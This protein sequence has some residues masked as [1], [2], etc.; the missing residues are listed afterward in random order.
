MPILALDDPRVARGVFTVREAAGYLAMP[1]STLSDWAS[2]TRSAPTIST[3]AGPRGS[4][5]VPFIGFAEAFVLAAFRRAGLPLQRIRPAVAILRDELGLEHA[6]AS[7]NLYT[8]GAEVLFDY[9]E[10]GEPGFLELTVVRTGQKQ[11]SELVREYLQRIR[12]GDDGWVDTIELPT[13]HSARVVVDAHRAFGLPLIVSGGARVEDVV[14][15]F[16]AGDRLSA[17]AKDFGLAVSDVEDVVRVAT[18]A[19]SAAA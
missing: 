17:I 4:A 15:R 3:V 9:A 18:Q 13:Y 12:Y 19:A 8:D 6:L 11:F 7:Q 10:R 2:A 14:D 16:V 5:R 1:V